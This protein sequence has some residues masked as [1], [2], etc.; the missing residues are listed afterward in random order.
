MRLT[1]ELPAMSPILP[2]P[3]L[4][5]PRS[6]RTNPRLTDA[7][8]SP[9][10]PQRPHQLQELQA[11]QAEELEW[12]VA[13]RTLRARAGQYRWGI[14]RYPL[15]RTTPKM[16]IQIGDSEV[17]EYCYIATTTFGCVRLYS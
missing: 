10:S 2:N 5:R 3:S 13:M 1:P 12:R 4:K 17:E 14:A 7:G 11:R 9:P 8:G 16:S 6:S 15:Q